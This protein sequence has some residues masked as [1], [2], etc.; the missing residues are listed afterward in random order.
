MV[1]T[2]LPGSDLTTAFGALESVRHD[3]ATNIVPSSLKRGFALFL[4]IAQLWV[5]WK[6]L[7]RFFFRDGPT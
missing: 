1:T 6:M 4:E 3:F 5:F 7:V 2:L